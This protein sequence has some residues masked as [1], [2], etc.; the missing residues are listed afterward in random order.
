[1]YKAEINTANNLGSQG[2]LA[3]AYA[4]LLTKLWKPSK[5]GRCYTV[6]THDCNT[7]V[8]PL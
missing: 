8:T 3:N 7:T 1:V 4:A 5:K 6:V 2:D